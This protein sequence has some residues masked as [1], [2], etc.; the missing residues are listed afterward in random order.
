MLYGRDIGSAA[1]SRPTDRPAQLAFRGR[2]P[3]IGRERAIRPAPGTQPPCPGRGEPKTGG[4]DELAAAPSGPGQERKDEPGRCVAAAV[5]V[6]EG[7][8]TGGFSA[9]GVNALRK[10]RS[11]ASGR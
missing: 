6:A 1:P 9:F 7:I 8:G 11:P 2:D 10:M 3:L 4:L 5:A